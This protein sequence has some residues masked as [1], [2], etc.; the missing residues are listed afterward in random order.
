MSITRQHS[1]TVVTELEGRKCSELLATPGADVDEVEVLYLCLDERWYRAYIDVGVLFLNESPGP[2]PED[3]LEPAA[4]Y[5]DLGQIHGV[6][7]AKVRELRMGDGVLRLTFDS[8]EPLIL[9]DEDEV[10]K[11]VRR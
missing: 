11:R 8:G 6:H 10:T 9:R 5:V 3:D 1:N 4:K 2:D 7:G